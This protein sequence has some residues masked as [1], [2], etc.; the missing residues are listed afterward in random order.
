[1]KVLLTGA[2]G[3]AGSHVLR[4]LLAETGWDVVCPV[5][6]RHRGNSSRLAAVLEE[7]A[8]WQDRTH[9][10]MHDLRAPF[11]AEGVRV[12]RCDMIVAAASE[13]PRRPQY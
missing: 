9:V 8:G 3:F 10:I 4:H 2:A 5:T 7:P 12:G 13:I 6:F 1:M 11:P